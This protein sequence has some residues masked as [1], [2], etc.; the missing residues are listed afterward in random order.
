MKVKRMIQEMMTG[1]FRIEIPLPNSPLRSVN[2]YFIK[3]GKRDLIIDPG[4]NEKECLESLQASLKRI[5]CDLSRADYFITHFHMDHLGGATAL[6]TDAS[7]IFLGRR[8]VRT[9]HGIMFGHLWSSVTHFTVRNGFPEA[10]LQEVSRIHPRERYRFTKRMDFDILEE[11]DLLPVGNYCFQCV[12]TPGHT[13]GHMCLH[14]PNKK[15]FIAGDHL[16]YEIT[17][18]ISLRSNDEN[19]LKAYFDSL[20]KVHAL[21][22]IDIVLPGHGTPFKKYRKRIEDL[23]GHARQ[24]AEK[25]ISVFQKGRQNAY[26]MA[27]Q[28]TW[29]MNV[30]SWDEVPVFQKWFA[31]GEV[32][33]HFKYL[34]QEGRIKR[35]MS[36]ENI[37]FSLR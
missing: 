16:L 35:E 37:A 19:P 32:I 11:N 6:K 22:P 31:V 4:M 9:V 26:Q 36:G 10:E 30:A 33:A 12:G 7:K 5:G 27:S 8:D 13:Q 15:I 24:R 18:N 3:G 23:E 20:K 17:P 2:C 29:D 34:E 21:E 25:M 28:I 1:L 14:E